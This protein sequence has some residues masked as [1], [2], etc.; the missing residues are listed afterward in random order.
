MLNRKHDSHKGDNGKVVVIGGSE[1]F[2]GAPILCALGAEYSGADLVHL[3][4]PP[5]HIEAAKAHSLNFILH[6]FDRD[7]MTLKDVKLITEVCQNLNADSVVIGPGLGRDPKTKE[8]IISLL[9]SFK[10]PTV[11]DADALIYTKNL[12]KTVILTPHRGEFTEM[13]GD[14]PTPS[15][16]QKW[17]KDLKATILCKGPLDVIANADNVSINETGNPL[18]TVGGTGDVLAGLVG[19]LMAQHMNAFDA[20]KYG[21]NVLCAAAD[22][23][24]GSRGSLKAIDILNE[25]PSMLQKI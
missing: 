8:A 17:A 3:I 9:E 7:V 23:L 10:I 6:H 4:L 24:A 13:T 25:I 16:I 11:V 14:E 1:G 21:V 19:G 12:P 5:C 22:H 15:N 2:Y 18:M 20:C